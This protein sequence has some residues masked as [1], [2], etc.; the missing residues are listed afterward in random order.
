[1]KIWGIF[2]NEG[3]ESEEA[4]LC[5]HRE[6]SQCKATAFTVGAHQVSECAFQR[7]YQGQ[8]TIAMQ[9]LGLEFDGF[10]ENARTPVCDSL[11]AMGRC[12]VS[13]SNIDDVDRTV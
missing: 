6:D 8:R 4:S 13:V 11:A 3:A 9:S 1:M 2:L 12:F 5:S 7:Q 10:A